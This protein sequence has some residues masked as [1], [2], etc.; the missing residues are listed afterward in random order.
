MFL[1]GRRIVWAICCMVIVIWVWGCWDFAIF[2]AVDEP[3]VWLDERLGE[4]R[5]RLGKLALP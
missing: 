5:L 2:A 3:I 4:V 1:R